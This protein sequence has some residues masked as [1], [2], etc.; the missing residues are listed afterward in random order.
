MASGGPPSKR[1][2]AGGSVEADYTPSLVLG[3]LYLLLGVWIWGSMSALNPRTVYTN[4]AT[5]GVREGLDVLRP[6]PSWLQKESSDF[7]VTDSGDLHLALSEVSCL[8]RIVQVL[9]LNSW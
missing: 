9:L 3:S 8:I 4:L 6:L 1:D 2:S 5:I 7:N